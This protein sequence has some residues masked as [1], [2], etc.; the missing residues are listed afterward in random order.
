M[1]AGSNST[2]CT[3]FKRYLDDCFQLKDLGPLKYFLGIEF[4]RSSEGLFLCQPKYALDILHQVDLLVAK[5]V[6]TPLPPNH[7]L[8]SDTGP[9]FSN[10]A[11]YKRLVG[12]LIYLTITR[13]DLSY[14]VHILSQFM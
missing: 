1:I 12:R 8:A 11:L 5:L 13:P 10:P 9:M 6:D 7:S 2:L 14:V 4:F 3:S